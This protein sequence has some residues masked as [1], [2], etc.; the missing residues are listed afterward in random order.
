MP[1][2]NSWLEA[3]KQA[4]VDSVTIPLGDLEDMKAV[5][6]ADLSKLDY[7][8]FDAL[9]RRYKIPVVIM[10]DAVFDVPK[11]L[12]TVTLKRFEV[13]PK[14]VAEYQYPGSF[15]IGSKELFI[16][17]ANDIMGI[18]KASGIP[19]EGADLDNPLAAQDIDIEYARDYQSDE[20]RGQKMMTVSVVTRSLSDWSALRRK[21]INSKLINNITVNSFSATQTEINLYYLGEIDELKRSLAV[22]G[23]DLIQQGDTYIIDRVQ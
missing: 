11:N 13:R 14:K 4:K 23:L 3:W 19:R 8:G 18:I 7:D 10:A 22:N 1:W 17:A 9:A 16:T 20:H 12:L 21:L 5:T 6:S 2:K 15:G